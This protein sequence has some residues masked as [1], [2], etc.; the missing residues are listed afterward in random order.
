MVDA[1]VLPEKMSVDVHPELV[2]PV[3]KVPPHVPRVEFEV[4]VAPDV[5]F[6]VDGSLAVREV[7]YF[8]GS[9]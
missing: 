5:V 1:V 3:L 4:D 8:G 6:A 7:D 9:V 2:R